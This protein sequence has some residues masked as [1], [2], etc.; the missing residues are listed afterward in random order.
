MT[1]GVKLVIKSG[2]GLVLGLRSANETYF[3][4]P[5][6]AVDG[7]DPRE[8]AEALFKGLTGVP[9]ELST[10]V[11]GRDPEFGTSASYLA[12]WD[13]KLVVP[14][15][16]ELMWVE[17]MEIVC[18]RWGLFARSSFN[19]LGLM[20]RPELDLDKVYRISR[21]AVSSGGEHAYEGID[22]VLDEFAF[23]ADI[24]KP[25]AIDDILKAI[26]TEGMH[27]DIL[28]AMQSVVEEI[29]GLKEGPGFIRRAAAEIELVDGPRTKYR[30]IGPNGIV[31]E[32][33][34]GDAKKYYR[35]RA[36][37]FGAMLRAG[38]LGEGLHRGGKPLE[39]GAQP[40]PSPEDRLSRSPARG[41]AY[42][43][44]QRAAPVSAS[45]AAAV[46]ADQRLTGRDGDGNLMDG[47]S[48][49]RA[50]QPPAGISAERA[51]VQ[52]VRL[53]EEDGLDEEEEKLLEQLLAIKQRRR[54]RERLRRG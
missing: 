2:D 11:R 4:L 1:C 24:G 15:G 14:D 31:S 5:S 45:E 21:K 30:L 49:N 34:R 36:K 25:E 33:V 38:K 52:P 10:I 9:A 28:D 51:D 20:D 44:F 27:A 7:G 16:M 41:A 17:P 47:R 26:R 8:A 50:F 13:G 43:S 48:G 22:M 29:P 35:N 40:R 39:R 54:A 12:E 6:V 46:E 37:E 19:K 18:G 3:N 32:D 42:P 23:L 53:D